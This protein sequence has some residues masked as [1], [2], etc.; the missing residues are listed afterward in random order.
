MGMLGLLLKV[1]GY[2]GLVFQVSGTRFRA[3][4]QGGL[5]VVASLVYPWE[6]VS[7]DWYS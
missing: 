5:A 6:L 2:G 1:V 4:K 3:V 7:Q